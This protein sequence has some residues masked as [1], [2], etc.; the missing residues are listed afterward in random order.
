MAILVKD[1]TWSQSHG[2]ISLSVPLKGVPSSKVDIFQTSRYVKLS[3]AP[4]LLEAFLLCEVKNQSMQCLSKDG[5]MFLEWKKS[6]EGVEW[7]EFEEKL[8]Y[9]TCARSTGGQK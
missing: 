3:F 8:R 7:A 5:K 9:E 1:H 6:D 2:S 4:F